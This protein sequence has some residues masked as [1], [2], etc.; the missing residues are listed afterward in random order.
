MDMDIVFDFTI[1]VEQRFGLHF[2]AKDAAAI[3]T[4]RKLANYLAA[5]LGAENAPGVCLSQQAFYR[6]RQGFVSALGTG[7]DQ[8]RPETELATLVRM[9]GRRESWARL[10]AAAGARCWPEL[11]RP[12]WLFWSLIGFNVGAALAI[13]CATW[14]LWAFLPA[15]F[16]A[17]GAAVVLGIVL[18]QVTVACKTGFR[19][20]Y[21]LVEDVIRYLLAYTPAEGPQ[22]R[23]TR[24]QIVSVVNALIV[25]ELRAVDYTEDTRWEDMDMCLAQ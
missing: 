9:T 18:A 13:F 5:R 22:C 11:R 16:A 21:E 6:V 8:V 2:S 14:L 3:T 12:A 10:R 23:W 4:P 25:E 20:R 19:K 7:R 15:V 1:A 17:V 24:H